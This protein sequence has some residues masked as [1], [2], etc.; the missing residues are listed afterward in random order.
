MNG[1]RA[2]LIGLDWQKEKTFHV[3]QAFLYS[4]LL[5]LQDCDVKMR[6]KFTFCGKRE[7]TSNDFLVLFLNFDKVF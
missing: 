7:D 2:I 6:P 4:S 3:Q 1:K 5:P